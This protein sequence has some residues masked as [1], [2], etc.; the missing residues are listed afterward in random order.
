M[1]KLEETGAALCDAVRTFPA[2]RLHEQR[3]RID[4]TWF[5]LISGELQHVIY[6]AG[7]VAMLKKA[8]RGR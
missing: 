4:D 6:H 5:G 3:P 8:G 1:R 7:Q 2:D